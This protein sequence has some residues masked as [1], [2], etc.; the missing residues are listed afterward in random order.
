MNLAFTDIPNGLKGAATVPLAGRERYRQLVVCNRESQIRPQIG[1]NFTHWS[2][3]VDTC[4]RNSIQLNN[5]GMWWYFFLQ[6]YMYIQYIYI[7][8]Y[9]YICIYRDRI[10]MLGCNIATT[11]S[12]TPNGGSGSGSNMKR[13]QFGGDLLWLDTSPLRLVN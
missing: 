7:Y 4:T 3:F 6:E 13:F 10:N 1:E 2:S 8:V 11:L 5:L 12:L 9:V